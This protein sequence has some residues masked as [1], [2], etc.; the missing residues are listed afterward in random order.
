MTNLKITTGRPQ[1]LLP[2][3]TV[4]STLIV[5]GGKG[6]GKTNFGSVIVEE[7]TKARLRWSVLDPLGVWWGLRH[8]ADGKGPGIECVILGGVHGDIPI[9]PTGGAVVA[10]LVIDEDANVVVDFSRRPGGKLWSKGE[11]IRFATDYALRLYERQGELVGGRRRAPLFVVLDEA[12]RYIPQQVRS[13]DKDVA[14]CVGAWE[15]LVEEGRNVGIGVGLLTQRSAR[16]NKSV[17]ELADAMVAFRTVGPLSLGAVLEWLGDHVPKERIKTLVELV[18]ALDVGS[19]L[20]VSPGWLR[21]EDVVSIRA[22]ETFDSSAT[23]KTGGRRARVTGKP[24][25]PALAKYEERMAETIERANAE[26]PKELRKQI[27][28]L[29]KELRSRPKDVQVEERV[30]EIRVEVPVFKDGEIKRLERVVGKLEDFGSKLVAVGQDVG[31]AAKEIGQRLDQATRLPA[32]AKQGG[33][34]RPSG[35]PAAPRPVRPA[36]RPAAGTPTVEKGARG[37]VPERPAPTPAAE[38]DEDFSLTGSHRRILNALAWLE[39]VGLAPAARVQ[40]AG[41][42][43]WHIRTKNFLNGLGAL[44]SNGYVTYPQPGHV[45]LTDLGREHAE[46]PSTPGTTEDLQEMVLRTVGGTKARIL[47]EIIDVYPDALSREDL[48][49]R[50]NYHPRTKA[51]LNGLGNLRSLGLIDYPEP[52]YV[53]ALPVLFLEEVPA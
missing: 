48:A 44:H 14:R 29:N 21:F 35:R 18:R 49:E 16:L 12:A 19:A 10:D 36:A 47:W 52:G 53:A 20:V 25:R 40:V 6:M 31:D 17:A 7:L 2:D 8:S 50:L 34:K 45:A 1:L 26:D 46:W 38:S 15:D 43:G 3:S 41:I 22:R 51:F 28:R 5:Y 32:G 30:E 4:T 9:E 37:P 42:A 11:R 33:Q 27:A 13:G 23:P 24:A 39:T